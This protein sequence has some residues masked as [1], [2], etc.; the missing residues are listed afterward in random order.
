M[1]R[2]RPTT[3]AGLAAIET[4]IEDDVP[5]NAAKVGEYL[6]DS[7]M[8]V[9]DRHKSIGDVRG[10]GLIEALEFVRDR[11]TKEPLAPSDPDAPMEERPMVV[12]SDGCLEDGLLL[13]PTMAGSMIRISPPL[14]ITK[15]EVDKAVEIIDKQ[16]TRVERKFL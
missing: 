11:E 6:L 14:I 13:M 2:R 9:Q 16:I 1:A 10:L 8:G 4:Y 12:I 15:E 7:L 3:A 5:E